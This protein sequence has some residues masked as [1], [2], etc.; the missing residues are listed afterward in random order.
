VA[1]AAP[2]PKKATRGH[3]VAVLRVVFAPPTAG[4][5]SVSSSQETARDTNHKLRCMMVS[6]ALQPEFRPKPQNTPTRLPAR[7]ATELRQTEFVGP[8][9]C[10]R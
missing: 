10:L 6:L 7:E 1:L 4:G 5:A 8:V 2:S 9:L 3:R